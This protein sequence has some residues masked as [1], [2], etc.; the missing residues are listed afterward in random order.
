MLFSADEFRSIFA[1]TLFLIG[2]LFVLAGFWKLMAFGL[3][4]HAQTLA[5]QSARLGQKSISED[6]SRVTQAAVQL[7]DSVNNLVRTSAGVGVFLI[8]VGFALLAATYVVMF[9]LHV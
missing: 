4:N 9:G 5:A 7:S 6:V 8:V 3:T 2:L 1:L